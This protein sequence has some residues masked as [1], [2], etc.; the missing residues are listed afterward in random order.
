MP[1]VPLTR[2]VG[3]FHHSDIASALLSEAYVMIEADIVD[4][5]LTRVRCTGADES[6]G[7]S[8]KSAASSLLSSPLCSKVG[9]V[10][11]GSGSSMASLAV[12]CSHVELCV[13]PLL[14]DEKLR[15]GDEATD[16]PMES[17][18]FASH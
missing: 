7:S 9:D 17:S 15:R 16:D 5:K 14:K 18:L 11:C 2:R 8:S 3:N 10:G 6:G 13:L 4:A 12:A 1:K